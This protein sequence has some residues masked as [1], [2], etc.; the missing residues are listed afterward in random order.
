MRKQSSAVA[1][2]NETVKLRPNYQGGG[3]VMNS[4]TCCLSLTRLVSLQ[5]SG[6]QI[7]GISG[8]WSCSNHVDLLWLPLIRPHYNSEHGARILCLRNRY[9]VTSPW[10]RVTSGHSH[11]RPRLCCRSERLCVWFAFRRI[12]VIPNP[13]C[14]NRA[15]LLR[16]RQRFKHARPH[17]WCIKVPGRHMPTGGQSDTVQAHPF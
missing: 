12:S 9:S 2:S 14:L 3:Q 13:H 6:I 17:C 4:K 5:T 8:R 1:N 16:A 10:H 11:C 7:V 15:S